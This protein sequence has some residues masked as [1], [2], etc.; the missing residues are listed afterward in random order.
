MR[1]KERIIVITLLLSAVVA[2]LLVIAFT[3]RAI[4]GV[5]LGNHKEHFDKFDL[6]K[7]SWDHFKGKSALLI[8]EEKRRGETWNPEKE[9]REEFMGR[10]SNFK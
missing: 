5:L 1:V 10:V 3:L 6:S 2:L 7:E 9:S 4:L 8:L